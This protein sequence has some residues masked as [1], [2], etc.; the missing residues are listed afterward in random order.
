LNES[1][2]VNG[3]LTKPSPK[4]GR[5]VKLQPR[6]LALL[7]DLYESV[8]LS[9]SQVQRRHFSGRARV[10]AVNALSRLR[11]AG[12]IR[13]LRMGTVI[14]QLGSV[15][16]GTVYHLTT[17]GLRILGDRLPQKSF[18]N[19]PVRIGGKD[20]VQDLILAEVW[21]KLQRRFPGHEFMHGKNLRM[22]QALNCQVPDLVMKSPKS[23]GQVAIELELTSKS[24]RRYRQIIFQ[25]RRDR[26]WDQVIYVVGKDSIGQ[27]ILAE[28]HGR[29]APS[30]EQPSAAG[31]FQIISLQ[32]LL[33][34]H[35][36][37][38]RA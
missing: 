19:C 35:Q 38:E 6:D 29:R 28:I 25:Y 12:F 32:S 23:I 30:L 16:V 33:K 22:P 37:G 24:E 1:P 21:E 5:A 15:Q 20:L 13:R 18:P 11:S 36:P 3:A 9:F 2:I 31:K 14:Y 8:Q 34:E 10:T 27:K 17:K 26:Q 4:S 7:N